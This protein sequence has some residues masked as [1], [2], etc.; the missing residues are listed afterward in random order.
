M[1]IYEGSFSQVGQESFVLN[2]LNEKRNGFYV[3]IGGYHSKHDSNTYL[4]ETVYGWSGVALEID[5]NRAEEYNQNR[6]NPCLNVNATSFDYLSYFQENNFPK[7][8]DYL[9]LDIEPAYQTLSALKSIPLDTYRFSVITF[10][11]D[12]YVNQNNALIKEDA[13]ELLNSFGY[14]LVF[15]NVQLEGKIFEDWWTDSNI[16]LDWIKE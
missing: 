7:T 4:L 6:S 10:E 5:K 9:Q 12:L 8:I 11:H 14:K 15:E 13:K 2:A 16:K 1:K 3:E